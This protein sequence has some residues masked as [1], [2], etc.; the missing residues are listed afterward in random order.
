MRKRRGGR[1]GRRHYEGEERDRPRKGNWTVREMITDEECAM[2]RLTWSNAKSNAKSDALFDS[3][4]PSPT[5]G[6]GEGIERGDDSRIQ[7]GLGV[8]TVGTVL[9]SRGHRVRA[10]Q[11]SASVVLFYGCVPV[12]A[13][14]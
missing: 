9:S 12:I 5:N 7:Q 6:D 8:V 1:C 4:S 2:R 11:A 13:D 14:E 10:V 3:T